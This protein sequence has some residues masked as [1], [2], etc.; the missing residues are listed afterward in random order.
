MKRKKKRKRTRTSNNDAERSS[1]YPTKPIASQIK[2]PR[3]EAKGSSQGASTSP[4]L[5]PCCTSVRKN[6]NLFFLTGT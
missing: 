4:L 2:N 1:A 5:H 3:R 6:I